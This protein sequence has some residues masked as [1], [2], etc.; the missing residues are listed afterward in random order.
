MSVSAINQL[1]IGNQ[2]QYQASARGKF[3]LQ[4]LASSEAVKTEK[5]RSKENFFQQLIGRGSQ[6][7][8]PSE[9]SFTDRL[10]EIKRIGKLLMQ[11][12]MPDSI[13][14][15]VKNVKGFMTEVKDQAYS[16]QKNNEGLF[17]KMQLVDN[18]LEEL[19]DQLLAD[20]QDEMQLVS[21]LGDLQG[22]LI[23]V[24]V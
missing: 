20:S 15:Y 23:D 5:P 10:A 4:A 6:A 17:E 19:G 3:D 22:L 12:P 8:S 2:N 21:S 24:F 18:K 11:Y 1:I 16:H 14:E 9:I 13:R 7:E